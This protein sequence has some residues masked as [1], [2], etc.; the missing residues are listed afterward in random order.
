VKQLVYEFYDLN[1]TSRHSV[2]LQ[3]RLID[4]AHPELSCKSQNST[5]TVSL[6]RSVVRND[7]QA[8]TR[9]RL[10]PD[11]SNGRDVWLPGGAFVEQGEKVI[12]VRSNADG[13]EGF[14]FIRTSQG[15]E[16]FIRAE[17]VGCAPAAQAAPLK[18]HQEVCHA[19]PL[20]SSFQQIPKPHILLNSSTA[21][22]NFYVAE[23]S[24]AKQP[25]SREHLESLPTVKLFELCKTQGLNV[26]G[27]RNDLV[28]RLLHSTT[29]GSA[30][31][32]REASGMNGTTASATHVGKQ[33]LCNAL[34]VTADSI[35]DVSAVL[36]E[37][38]KLLCLTFA[39][40]IKSGMPVVSIEG[41]A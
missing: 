15:V 38:C 14:A 4:F 37:L 18:R 26:N 3:K 33:L 27:V 20:A 2:R 17:Y 29:A 28:F 32:S 13:E 19:V 5:S 34:G 12:V 21:S 9:L 31:P 40:L 6:V 25:I 8:S 41:C 30:H 35:E 11:I 22:S 36:W 7:G 1:E 39:Q 23:I 16:G 24:A 10:R